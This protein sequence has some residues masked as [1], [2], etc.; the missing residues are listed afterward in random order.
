MQGEDMMAVRSYDSKGE[1]RQFLAGS[2]PS[3][4]FFH[5]PAALYSPPPSYLTKGDFHHKKEDSSK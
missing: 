1:G 4:A 2:R 5:H 3:E